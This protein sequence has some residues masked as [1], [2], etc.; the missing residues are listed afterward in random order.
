MQP[1]LFKS[2]FVKTTLA[3]LLFFLQFYLD[4]GESQGQVVE[5]K[6]SQEFESWHR[7]LD[8]L[9]ITFTPFLYGCTVVLKTQNEWKRGRRWP[10]TI[11]FHRLVPRSFLNINNDKTTFFWTKQWKEHEQV[12][13]EEEALSPF[14]P[15]WPD[16]T[17]FW[18]LGNF[19]KP[20]VTINLSKSPTFF[21]N[22][23]NCVN[24]YH[25]S[26]EIIFV[27]LLQTF[28]DFHWSHYLQQKTN[29]II[30]SHS[31]FTIHFRK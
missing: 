21:G 9:F 23:C 26:S 4:R 14:Q 10:I 16:W 11:C 19:L 15:V 25:F 13:E 30:T 1:S 20:L 28:G 27:Q 7:I 18:T 2:L 31:C 17:F 22:F 3:Y 29:K 24:I 8:G 5:I 6:R 12:K